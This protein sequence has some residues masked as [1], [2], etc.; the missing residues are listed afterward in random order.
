MSRESLSKPDDNPGL[1]PIAVLYEASEAKRNYQKI[2]QTTR[3]SCRE[4]AAR[5]KITSNVWNSADD[6]L[7]HAAAFFR[8]KMMW[9][10][11]V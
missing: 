2:C 5:A 8:T 7:Q 10:T 4:Q 6:G 3:R 1:S 9:V 11:A